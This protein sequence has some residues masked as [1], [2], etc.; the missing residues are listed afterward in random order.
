MTLRLGGDGAITGCTSLEEPAISI[1][2]LTLTTPIEAVS[3]TAAAPSYT[4]SGDT[5]NGLYYAGTNS[6]GVSTAGTSAIVVDAS[7]RVGIGT[8]SPGRQLQINGDSDT[9]IRVVAASG[10]SA[11]IQFGDADDSVMGGVNFDASDDSLQ[12][13]GFNNSE[14]MRIDS[15]GYLGVGTTNPTSRLTVIDT[16]QDIQ[17][18]FGSLANACNPFI[19]LQGRDAANTGNRFA[20][21]QLDAENQ[22]LLLN[23]PGT[24]SATIGTN[25]VAV[26]STGRLLVG[27]TSTTGLSGNAMLSV[28]SNSSSAVR[29]NLINSG[30]SAVESTQFGSQNNDIFFNASSSEKMRILSGGGITFNGDTATANALDD[31]EEGTWTPTSNTGTI[32]TSKAI[33]TKIGRQV[34]LYAECTTFS[35]RTSSDRVEIT[36]LPFTPT[37]SGSAVGSAMWR[38][39]DA[40]AHTVY[41]EGNGLFFYVSNSGNWESLNYSELNNASSGVYFVATYMV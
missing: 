22:L 6:I 7:Q 15:S 39:A 1:S 31:Y 17:A 30:S 12:F 10:G 24:N 18:R 35:D 34:T 8:T 14:A 25:P 37:N 32:A 33:Y 21:I 38:Y 41:M 5:D 19:R 27:T 4:F 9:Q 3:G 16:T 36:G 2:G 20:D 26:D 13:R 23:D 11:G 28:D 29:I 40:Q